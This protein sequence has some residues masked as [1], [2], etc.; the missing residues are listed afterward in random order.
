MSYGGAH[1]VY[2]RIVISKKRTS[3]L[4]IMQHVAFVKSSEHK[5]IITIPDRL[6]AH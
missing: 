4:Q 6:I 1:C 5:I 2:C 3:L